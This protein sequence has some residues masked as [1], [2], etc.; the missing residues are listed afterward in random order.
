M[1][2]S[3]R[4]I[5]TPREDQTDEFGEIVSI[6]YSAEEGGDVAAAGACRKSGSI[7]KAVVTKLPTA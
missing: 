7:A 3:W 6:T 5:K 1:R 4:H 2:D